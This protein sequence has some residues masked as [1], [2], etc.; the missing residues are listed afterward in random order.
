VL[1]G[2][3]AESSRLTALL[4]GAAD[5]RGGA[6][7]V[8]GEA[9]IG[10]TALLEDAVGRVRD[11]RVLRTEGV[12]S[13]SPLA[14]AAL[15]RLL[16]PI[17]PL[18]GRLPAPQARALRVALGQEAGPADDRFLV[19]LAVLTLLTEAAEQTPVLGV[20]DDAHWLDAASAEALLF[21]A[22]RL[23]ADRVALV[24]AA[25]EGEERRFEAAGL[26][27]LV[28]A[29]ID[30]AAGGALLAERA[31]SPVS[32]E[33]RDLLMARTGGNP[34]ALVELPAA[35]TSAQLTGAA[36]LP[37]QLPLTE[38]VIRAFLDRCRRLSPTAQTLLLVAAADD[39][40]STATIRQ[41]AALLGVEGPALDAAERSGLIRLRDT[42]LQL[43]HPL[44]RSAVYGAAATTERQRAHRALAEVFRRQDDGDRRAWH[45][46]LAMEHPDDDVAAELDRVADR[47]RRQGGH[48]AASA[49]WER[50]AELTARAEPRA[51]R[52]HAAAMSAWVAGQVDR[53]RVLAEEARGHT[54]RAALRADIDA[55]RG[56]LAWNVGS[57][58]CGLI[59]L[60]AAHEVIR[61]DEVRGLEM[62]MLATSLAAV[63][64]H[65]VDPAPL[66]RPVRAEEPARGRCLLGLLAGH[67]H[68]Y[69]GEIAAGA[70]AFRAASAIGTTLPAEL[71]LLVN[72]ALAALLLGDD[73]GARRHL[74]RIDALTRDTGALTFRLYVPSRLPFADLPGGRWDAVRASAST[75]LQLAP[76]MGQAA[77]TG[78]P[79]AWLALLA[80]LRGDPELDRLLGEVERVRP[81]QPFGILALADDVARWARG[82]AA[83]AA[84]DAPAALHQLDRIAHPIL[85]RLAALDTVEA[86][87]RAGAPERVRA[88]AAELHTFAV[89]TGADWAAAVASHARALLGDGDEADAQFNEALARHATAGRPV[90][91]ART[92]LA[93]GE[94]LRRAGRR[95]DARGQLRGALQT[96]ADVG[97]APWADRARQE[98]RA[99]GDTARRRDPSTVAD[100]TPQEHQVAH[101][102][103][104]GL[105]NR[106]VAGRLFLS[107]R[108]IEYHLSNAYLKLGVRS[109]GELSQLRLS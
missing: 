81:A 10:K 69:R 60:Q 83:A 105:S 91:R 40:G 47:A 97:A 108:T 73:E 96:F 72:M 33:V 25:R 21:V 65:P 102:V 98:L 16:R 109:R 43:R 41:A 36:R 19:F 35:L 44:V 75:A 67:S 79:W 48:E 14:F 63:G 54:D 46:S 99:S 17:L 15:H 45:L 64:G 90:A 28:L 24:F 42:Q 89:D 57:P 2:R 86:A 82:V 53:A 74:T 22:R 50:A 13:E 27:E 30:P 23:Q 4:T 62:A 55:L 12:E 38:R 5:S 93:Y 87:D 49:A 39:S 3:T 95:V 104:R 71:D 92:Q 85:R 18:L 8:R 94:F 37:A 59:A 78:L 56:R 58:E 34:L 31:G 70:R 26:P 29:G 100:L 52:L 107:V 32:D 88:C 7:V 9:G 77:L 11:A 66:L 103:S 76:S 1:H 20:V 51:A 6:L 68:V 61:T 80:A 84:G 106:E 101:L